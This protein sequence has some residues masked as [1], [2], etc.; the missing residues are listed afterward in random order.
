MAYQRELFTHHQIKRLKL[1]FKLS[2]D[3]GFYSFLIIQFLKE[4]NEVASI[5]MGMNLWLAPQIS[6]H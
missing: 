3:L 4:L 5:T 2:L 1:W 6:E